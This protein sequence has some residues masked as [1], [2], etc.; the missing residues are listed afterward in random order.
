M[1]LPQDQVQA[2][3]DDWKPLI[4]KF[5]NKEPQLLADMLKA[6]LDM[7]ATQ[8]ESGISHFYLSN[9]GDCL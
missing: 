1:E 8:D 6:I 5:S 4:S 2:L 7:I 9:L 3:L